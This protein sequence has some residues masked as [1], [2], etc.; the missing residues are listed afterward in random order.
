[1]SNET[2]SE[3]LVVDDDPL[4]R[5]LLMRAVCSGGWKCAEAAGGLEAW[6]VVREKPPS[7]LLLDFAMP[8]LN[9]A[10]L[11][12]RMRSDPNPAIAQIPTSML[13]GYVGT[14]SEVLCLEAGADDFVT[15][16]IN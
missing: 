10:E 13:T 12:K 5:Q 1:M 7:L 6:Q 15:Q 9:G 14:E 11:L 16:P 4:S 8:D 3:I 2:K